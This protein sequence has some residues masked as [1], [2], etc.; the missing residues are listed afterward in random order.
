MLSARTNFVALVLLGGCRPEG[1]APPT[2]GA[3][4]A[5]RGDG[6]E[7]A[8]DRGFAY[9]QTRRGD[10]VETSHGVAIADPYRWLE[11]LDSPE[12]R[13]WVEAQNALTFGY[14]GGIPEREALRKRLTAVWNYERWGLPWHEGKTWFVTKNDGLQN[15]AV[16]YTS[17]APKGELRPLLDPN[18]LSPDGTVA[19][20]GLAASPDG[21]LLAY[22]LSS[23]GSDW[24][25]WHVRDVATGK[26]LVDHLRWVKFSG[27]S[28]SHDGKGFYY[29]RYDEPKAGADG[30][31]GTNYFQK[32]YYHRIGTP[33][34]ADPLVYERPD[35]KEWGFGGDVTEDGRWLLIPVRQGTSPKNALFYQDLRQVATGKPGKPRRTVELLRNFDAR[36]EFLG[37]DG[38]VFYLRTDLGAP[39]GRVIAIDVRKPDPSAWRE[40]VPHAE[41]TLESASIV[42]DRLFLE[43]LHHAHSR[44]E[45]RD[46]QGKL[47][48]EL[49]LPG[50][51]SVSGL[52]G[53]RR[54]RE[55]YYA[56]TSYTNP[57]SVLRYD[58]ETG[59]SEV[60]RAPAL[61][62]SPDD[63]VTD[64]VF[65]ASKDGT[66]IPMFLSRRKDTAKNPETPVYLYGYGGFNASMT[67]GFSPADLVWMELGGVLAVANL[68]GGGEYGEEWHQAGTKLAKQNVFDDF[69]A[70]GEWLVRE[71][72]TRRERLA[73]G[74]R[75]NGGLLVGAAITQRPDLFAAALPGVGVMDMLRFHKFT[76]GWAWQSDYGSP[77]DPKEFAALRA[78]SPL[79]NVK[80]ETAYPATLVYT[81]DHDDRVVP[82]HSY[83][84][85]SA[86]QH[87]HTGPN[88]VMIRID[89]K[90]GHGAGKPTAKRIEEWADL[91]G[92][93]VK[94][95]GIRLPARFGD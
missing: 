75:S 2:E 3:E 18:A 88:P 9:P 19:L 89:V 36:Y 63:F 29:A 49:E 1:T 54:D 37:N 46:L 28:W 21:K 50:I 80:D 71:G 81:A 11:E 44:V 45:V 8:K 38:S 85:V 62:F 64:Q 20:S 65:Y 35:Q 67:P 77:D 58:L 95:L 84:F 6:G 61:A 87:A 92:F 72:W 66:K 12:T 31:T 25:E 4:A 55:T 76:I 78:Y 41:D 56:F 26:D 90:A 74:G 7:G 93:L 43:Y 51:G 23:A 68:R 59:T 5:G 47:E 73:V 17:N 79:H 42:G 57:G 33:Q 14:L 91:W 15:Q 83:K 52:G 32:L 13:S 24:Q 22:G 53:K 70:A 82:G 16:L 48:R 30:F 34:S 94:N 69:I 27:A 39:R 60:H 40:I 10:V 86:L